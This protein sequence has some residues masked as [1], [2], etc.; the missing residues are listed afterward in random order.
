[1]RTARIVCCAAFAVAI[2]SCG[3]GAPPPGSRAHAEALL[4][5][6]L[7]SSE[8]SARAA[9]V[10]AIGRLRATQFDDALARLEAD[11]DPRVQAALDATRLRRLDPRSP[12][13]VTQ[14]IE[15]LRGREAGLLEWLPVVSDDASQRAILDAALSA[16]APQTRVATLVRAANSASSTQRALAARGL[17]DD[18]LAVRAAA[19]RLAWASQLGPERTR[20]LRTLLE[21]S[22]ERKAEAAAQLADHGDTLTVPALFAAAADPEG[23]VADVARAAL[24]R[25][26]SPGACG[27]LEAVFGVR[28]PA[29][30]GPAAMALVRSTDPAA[31]RGVQSVLS[32]PEAEI[33]AI[34]ACALAEAP[35]S[36]HDALA[37][38]H[39]DDADPRA[40]ACA[41]VAALG[42]SEVQALDVVR[43]AARGSNPS[44]RAAL[45]KALRS[46]HEGSADP[47]S[48]LGLRAL[49]GL[50]DD[51]LSPVEDVDSAIAATT[52]LLASR[53]A[54]VRD[55][56]A[57]RALES[58]HPELRLMAALAVAEGRAADPGVALTRLMTD[59]FAVVR[60][61][62]AAARL[63]DSAEREAPEGPST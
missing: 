58:A 34:A 28:D 60:V 55:S 1:V 52:T 7:A 24:C 14:L 40:R 27:Q 50:D 22:A 25:L 11:P 41:A 56:A 20:A 45:A 47:A 21:G 48:A 63:R 44:L 61:A 32:H 35:P 17:E 13:V 30:V 19:A 10:D 8:A 16:R 18:D 62:A 15:R 33:R 51:T 39:L 31:T 53:E 49:A 3:E 29:R 37:L 38:Q 9:A 2:A 26:G 57:S 43:A 4:R 36:V 42:A 6:A 23:V 54:K 5:E 59:P 46:R 12:A